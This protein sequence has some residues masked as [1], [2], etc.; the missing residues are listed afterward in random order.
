MKSERRRRARLSYHGAPMKA[1]TITAELVRELAVPDLSLE[2]LAYYELEGML[3]DVL[4]HLDA[5]DIA[6]ARLL[7]VGWLAEI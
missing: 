1:Q 3:L 5:G 7:F 6:A 2:R 4:G